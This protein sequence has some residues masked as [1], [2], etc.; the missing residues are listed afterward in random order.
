M[1]VMHMHTSEIQEGFGLALRCITFSGITSIDLHDVELGKVAVNKTLA[2]MIAG[3]MLAPM[4]FAQASCADA[5]DYIDH[6]G[7]TSVT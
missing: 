3:A 1:Q 4:A 5:H 6:Y 7:V 2:V